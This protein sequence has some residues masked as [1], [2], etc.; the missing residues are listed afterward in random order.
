MFL[1]VK[2]NHK[3][4]IFYVCWRQKFLQKLQSLIKRFFKNSRNFP[5]WKII[6]IGENSKTIENEKIYKNLGIEK[7]VIDYGIVNEEKLIKFYLQSSALVIPSLNEGFNFPLL[8]ALAVGC[9]GIIIQA[10]QYQRKLD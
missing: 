2:I 6:V 3:Q 10:Y 5:E 8:E 7:N 1:N 4:K 9:P